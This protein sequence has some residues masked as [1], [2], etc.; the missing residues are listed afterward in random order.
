M[1]S[2]YRLAL[3]QI[4]FPAIS[5][6]NPAMKKPIA[7]STGSLEA[8][9]DDSWA[10]FLVAFAAMDYCVRSH[11]SSP[12]RCL[13]FPDRLLLH[14]TCS[15]L[16]RSRALLAEAIARSKRWPRNFSSSS[17]EWNRTSVQESTSWTQPSNWLSAGFVSGP[18]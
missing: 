18:S 16:L 11:F 3:L 5:A 15:L 8:H 1:F 9:E 4:G 14:G 2:S 10:N 17:V 13:L 6:S 7:F 12:E